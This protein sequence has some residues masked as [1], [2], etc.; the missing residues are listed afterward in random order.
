MNLQD[1]ISKGTPAVIQQ[2]PPVLHCIRWPSN[3]NAPN[4]RV[5]LPTNRTI[6]D[7]DKWSTTGGAGEHR[8]TGMIG[9]K[10]V[11]FGVHYAHRYSFWSISVHY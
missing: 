9:H 11:L 8:L 10:M 4:V 5:N 2:N 6:T 3:K 1:V 7:D